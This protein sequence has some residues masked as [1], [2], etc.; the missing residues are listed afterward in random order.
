MSPKLA[1]LVPCGMSV[2]HQQHPGHLTCYTDP[3]HARDLCGNGGA[4]SAGNGGNGGN[5]GVGN[6]SNINKALIVGQ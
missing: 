5:G 4:L 3:G 1:S 6:G 2:L